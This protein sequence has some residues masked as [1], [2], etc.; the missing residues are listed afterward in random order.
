MSYSVQVIQ[1]GRQLIR[2]PCVYYLERYDGWE[3]FIVT[4]L[5]IRGHDKTI[6]VNTGLPKDL[7]VLEPYWPTWLMEQK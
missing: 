4:M 1:V 5:V 6:V 7:A 2:P 3:P